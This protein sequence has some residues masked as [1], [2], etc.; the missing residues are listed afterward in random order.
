MFEDILTITKINIEQPSFL[1]F[2]KRKTKR[3]NNGYIC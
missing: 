2:V 3:F 1:Q